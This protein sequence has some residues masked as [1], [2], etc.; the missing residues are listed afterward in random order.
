MT[1]KILFALLFTL[2]SIISLNLPFIVVFITGN[3][4]FM[5]LFTVSWIPAIMFLVFAKIVIED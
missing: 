5:F 4:W 2:L 1:I 3:W